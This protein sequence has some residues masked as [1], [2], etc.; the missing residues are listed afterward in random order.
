MK[1]ERNLKFKG[2]RKVKGRRQEAG[3]FELVLRHET[4]GLKTRKTGLD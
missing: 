3:G 2:L 4:L 1:P